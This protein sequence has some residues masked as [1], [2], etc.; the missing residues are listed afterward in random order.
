MPKGEKKSKVLQETQTRS[1]PPTPT[2]PRTSSRRG[3][4]SGP[5]NQFLQQGRMP[6]CPAG[7]RLPIFPGDGGV[8]AS[9]PSLLARPC[10]NRQDRTAPG[11]TYHAICL[12]AGRGQGEGPQ[13][14]WMLGGKAWSWI[15]ETWIPVT[16][17]TCTEFT[18]FS[19]V[20]EVRR[21]DPR[22]NRGRP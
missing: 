22:R 18:E 3:W 20:L 1:M 9:C 4:E 2:L 14:Q 17:E 7:M 10:P 12:Q 11:L 5:G 6:R 16:A 8:P 21:T 13:R 15:S 19:P